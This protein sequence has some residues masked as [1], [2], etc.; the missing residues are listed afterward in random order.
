MEM[1]VNHILERAVVPD[2]VSDGG[3]HVQYG[4]MTSD[5]TPGTLT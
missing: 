1:L 3:I 5:T 2:L 4:G